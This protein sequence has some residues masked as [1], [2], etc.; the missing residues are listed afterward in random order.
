MRDVNPGVRLQVVKKMVK[1]GMDLAKLKLCDVYQIM[2]DGLKNMG[3]EVR[4]QSQVLVLQQ[5]EML[6]EKKEEADIEEE[7]EPKRR[8]SS[9]QNLSDMKRFKN[10]L[11]KLLGILQIDRTLM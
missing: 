9:K 11:H 4:K 1:N 6:R 5:L 3:E 8:L 10:A 7:P 2:H